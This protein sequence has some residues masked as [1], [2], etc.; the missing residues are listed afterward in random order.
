MSWEL[1]CPQCFR[2]FD[3]VDNL[4]EVKDHG[5]CGLCENETHI[6]LDD[7]I[8]VTFT[9]RPEVRTLRFHDPAALSSLER[10]IHSTIARGVRLADGTPINGV[11]ELRDALAAEP[12]AFASTVTEKL[13]IYALGRGL[14]HY[15]MPVVRQILRDAKFKFIVAENMSDAA[16]KVV[17]AAKGA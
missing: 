13:M 3:F 9:V 14:R 10:N 17:A 16:A 8:H 6:A 15:D 12:R 4:A 2:L 5:W 1:I 11:T 7:W